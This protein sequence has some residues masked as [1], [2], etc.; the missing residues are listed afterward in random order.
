MGRPRNE[1]LS[2]LNGAE[3]HTPLIISDQTIEPIVNLEIKGAAEEAFM[4]EMVEVTVLSTGSDNEEPHFIVNV[5]GRNQAFIRDT[6]VTCKR[7][8]LEVLARCKQT[9]YK[10]VQNP[11]E[12]E[13]YDM[14]EKTSFVY[15]FTVFDQNPK[16]RAWLK[17]V[18][19]ERA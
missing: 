4:N 8:F 12:I 2:Q 10:Q 7:M 17:A 3:I 13:R 9:T 11:F 1:E 16:G 6:P 15:P 5:N 14:Q 18:K 19:E